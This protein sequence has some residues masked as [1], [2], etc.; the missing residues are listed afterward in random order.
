MFTTEVGFGVCIAMNKVPS[1]KQVPSYTMFSALCLIPNREA[2]QNLGGT[3][4]AASPTSSTSNIG[5]RQLAVVSKNLLS[6]LS[7]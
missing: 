4:K 3:H 7:E 5:K 6:F 2:A 1:L